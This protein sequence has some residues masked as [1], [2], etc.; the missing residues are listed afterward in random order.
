MTLYV[1]FA[2]MPHTKST[3]YYVAPILTHVGYIK[4]FSILQVQIT[5]E[6]LQETMIVFCIF[7]L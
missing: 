6:Y 4:D 7:R 3:S 1:F 5:P 2:A